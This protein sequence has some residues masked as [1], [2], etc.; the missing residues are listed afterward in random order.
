MEIDTLIIWVVVG[1]VTG[2]A[3]EILMGGMRIGLMGAM[4]LGIAGA[5]LSGW[6]FN[7]FDYH[8]MTGLFGIIAEALIGSVI[9]LLIFGVFRKY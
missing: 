3:L 1:A 4:L 9:L 2:I 8:F 7:F 5:I 6:V